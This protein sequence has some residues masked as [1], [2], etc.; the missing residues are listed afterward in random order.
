M[1]NNIYISIKVVV[2]FLIYLY[3]ELDV[4]LHRSL[5]TL[6]RNLDNDIFD[7]KYRRGNI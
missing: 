3:H 7:L 1:L 6:E 4:F 2:K 5:V